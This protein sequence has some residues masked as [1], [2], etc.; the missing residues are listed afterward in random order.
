MA[1]AG[2]HLYV[3]P[4]DYLSLERSAEFKSEYF[5]GLIYAMSG[6][7]P[8]PSAIAA[9]VIRALGNQLLG[10]PCQVYTSDLKVATD[11]AGFFAY[12]DLSII[13]G[14]PR[15][16]DEHQD[17]VTNPTVIVEVLSPSTE[18][19][20]RGRKFAQ[21][22]RIASLND[23]I[24]IAQDQPRVELFT[25][26]SG[27]HWDFSFVEGLEATLSIASID[28]TLPLAQVYDKIRFPPQ[29]LTLPVTN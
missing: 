17:A 5:H 8:A 3:S 13:C 28:C 21:Y 20:D 29:P 7:S 9:N 19:Y 15:R 14:E 26:Q 4:T 12:P 16:Y 11:D 27:N 25:R 22:Q 10:K 6:G 24:L 1:T 2:Q 18:A 23:Y